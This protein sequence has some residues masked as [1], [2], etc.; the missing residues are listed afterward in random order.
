MPTLLGI[1]KYCSNNMVSNNKIL[2]SFLLLGVISFM[3]ISSIMSGIEM[4]STYISAGF[5]FVLLVNTL[6]SSQL[7]VTGY[8]GIIVVALLGHLFATT[9]KITSV[10]LMVSIMFLY[11]MMKQYDF[12]YKIV[13]YP[14]LLLVV[15]GFVFTLPQMLN[16]LLVAHANRSDLYEGI[17]IN[18]NSN[19]AFYLMAIMSAVL[20]L[21]TP[22]LRNI[23]V[24][25]CIICV[26]SC[27]SRNG[28]LCLFTSLLFYELL[29]SK[30]HRYTIGV[31]FL[32]LLAA[33]FYL[34]FVE[35]THSIDFKFMGKDG[36]S[37]GRSEQI[38]YIIN[39]FSVNLFG[40]GKDVIN[41]ATVKLQG[42]VVHNFYV[43]SLYS[44]GIIIMAAY[45]YF[46]YNLFHKLC[47]L[48]AKA[49]LLSFNIYFFFEPGLCYYYAFI[50]VFPIVIALLK[51][52]EE[53]MQIVL[54]ENDKYCDYGYN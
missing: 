10:I 11:E 4:S 17:F 25:I 22:Y 35:V 47:S 29:K 32:I 50:N 15:I 34:V 53:R 28:I 43:C 39:H 16:S 5:V 49:F 52:N 18:A 8:M 3:L 41:G 36:N 48:A 20:F 13:I 7:R 12:S 2:N 33:V 27:G 38:I 23:F 46:I 24:V 51:Y 44:S 26:Y 19:A 21:E 40:Y 1:T 30:Y 54:G 31:F 14:F 37:A 45:L 9:D 42:F 6:L